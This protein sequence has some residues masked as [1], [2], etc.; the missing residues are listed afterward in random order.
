[1]EHRA[2]QYWEIEQKRMKVSKSKWEREEK[3]KAGEGKKMQKAMLWWKSRE[4]VKEG[5][6]HSTKRWGVVKVKDKV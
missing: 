5:V 2:G 4:I 3:G 1:M 6:I